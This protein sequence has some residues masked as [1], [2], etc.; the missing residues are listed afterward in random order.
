MS[1]TFRKLSMDDRGLPWHLADWHAGSHPD[2]T[3]APSCA[4]FTAPGQAMAS[5]DAAAVLEPAPDMG[6]PTGP[7]TW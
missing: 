2:T 5:R 1:E 4:I 7:L 6:S 3:R